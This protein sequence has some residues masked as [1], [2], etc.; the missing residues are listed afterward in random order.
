MFHEGNREDVD[1]PEGQAQMA[2][3]QLAGVQ[4]CESRQAAVTMLG[5]TTSQHL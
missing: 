2:S 5:L 3:H 4:V 1:R